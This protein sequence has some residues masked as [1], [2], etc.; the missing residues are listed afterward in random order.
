[1]SQN[2]IQDGLKLLKNRDFLE[3]FVAYFI[4]YSGT[5]MAPIAMA[6][7]VLDLT[8]STNGCGP[9]CF[10]SRSSLQ[11]WKLSLV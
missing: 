5:A 2:S 11:R 9:L 1:M 3:L 4:S 7:G 8:G 6:F 10:S